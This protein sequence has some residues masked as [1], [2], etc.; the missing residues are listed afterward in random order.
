MST[1]FCNNYIQLKKLGFTTVDALEP[2][3]GMIKLAKEK[4]LYRILLNQGLSNDALPYQTGI[5]WLIS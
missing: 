5:H 1:T 4:K 3:E 2:S